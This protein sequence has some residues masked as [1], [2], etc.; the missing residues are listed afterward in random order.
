MVWIYPA[1]TIPLTFTVFA[2]WLVWIKFRPNK[3]ET[4]NKALDEKLK[5]NQ[6]ENAEQDQP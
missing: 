1:V 3:M 4:V 6:R 2:T 5:R